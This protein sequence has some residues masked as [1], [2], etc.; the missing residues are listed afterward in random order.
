MEESRSLFTAFYYSE[1]GVVKRIKEILACDIPK[2]EISLE[3]VLKPFK[4]NIIFSTMKF[5]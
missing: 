2:A 5:K 3:K 1:T 4:K